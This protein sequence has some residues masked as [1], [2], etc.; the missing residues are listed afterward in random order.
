MHTRHHMQFPCNPVVTG[1]LSDGY[2]QDGQIFQVNTNGNLDHMA[3]P[4]SQVLLTTT[5]RDE[6][7]FNF[8]IQSFPVAMSFCIPQ[9]VF[10]GI[11]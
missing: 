11:F 10:A 3:T 4:S 7:N 2:F 1:K 6:G 5:S 8:L 9:P